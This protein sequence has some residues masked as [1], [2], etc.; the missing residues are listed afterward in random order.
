M[1]IQR[2]IDHVIELFSFNITER[3]LIVA[4]IDK[5]NHSPARSNNIVD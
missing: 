4:N 2:L 3:W 1:I 5:I